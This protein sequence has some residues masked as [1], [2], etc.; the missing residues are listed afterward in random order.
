MNKQCGRRDLSH[1]ILRQAQG[2]ECGLPW[3][4]EHRVERFLNAG[5]DAG[6]VTQ[7]GEVVAEQRLVVREKFH[8]RAHVL[9]GRL[10]TPHSNQAARNVEWN[11]DG[12][13]ENHSVDPVRVMCGQRESQGATERVADDV[14]AP[15]PQRI[16]NVDRVRGP[17]LEIV[18]NICG[19]L[20]ETEADDVGSDH[21]HFLFEIGNRQPPICESGH[22]W[23]GAV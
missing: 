16:E 2:V 6:L 15:N 8:D 7:R 23:T 5:A 11:A 17:R 13:H 21:R 19:P 20:G 18:G 14:R 12:T 3:L 9:H 10:V 22:S 4:W 1:L